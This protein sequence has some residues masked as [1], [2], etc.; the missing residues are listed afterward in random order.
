[1]SRPAIVQQLETVLAEYDPTLAVQLDPNAPFT[2]PENE[3]WVR[4]TFGEGDERQAAVGGDT[5]PYRRP[6]LAFVDAFAPAG[7]GTGE[8]IA[9]IAAVRTG[10]RRFS[11]AGF[12]WWKFRAG[13]EG[14]DPY[15]RYRQQLI[16]QFT[17]TER[18]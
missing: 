1:M 9:I 12:R 7:V 2:P 10:F 4:L 16:I 14:P 17:L 13:P 8:V 5:A 15:G 18:A 3:H 6:L 11:G